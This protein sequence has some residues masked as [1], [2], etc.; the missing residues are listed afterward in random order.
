MSGES[1]SG[2]N[3]D[4]SE[5]PEEL[6]ERAPCALFSTLPNGTIAQGN[7]TFFEWLRAPRESIVGQVR[8]QTLLTIGSRMYYETHYAPLLHM[9]GFVSEIALDIRRADGTVC[10]VVASAK[11]ICDANGVPVSNRVA[12]FDSTDRR[13]YEQELLQARKVAEQ[14]VR[15][16]ADA[17]RQKNAF[18]AMLAHELRNPLAPIRNAVEILRR[19]E[20]M[21]DLTSRTSL[22]MQRQVAQMVRLVEDLL[23]VSRLG[24]AKLAVQRVPVDLV[25]VVR[26]AIEASEGQLEDAG[27]RL[28]ADWPAAPVYVNGDAS[29]LIQVV[30]NI[31][32]NAAKFTPRDGAVHLAVSR[33]DTHAEIRVRD[34]GIGI[35]AAKLSRIFDLFMQ[36][37]I[38]TERRGGL[39]IGL[40]LAKNLV[41][42]HDGEITAH[43]GGVGEGTEFVIRIP[44]LT[45][46]LEGVSK[47]IRGQEPD[48]AMVPKRILVVDDNQD[49]ADMMATLLDLLGHEVKTTY[50][51][52]E[53][54]E[55]AETFRPH[56]ILL[57]IGLPT[58]SGY[59]A[60]ERIR[61]HGGPQPF[62]VALTGWGQTEDRRKSSAA[63]FDAHLIK[64]VEHEVLAK[65]IAD[66]P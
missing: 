46:V 8:F 23:D 2:T 11:Q 19:T 34:T 57:D 24:Q 30:G 43:S 16:L 45:G 50:D 37:E 38:S 62:L 17:D 32:H 42:Q 12:L 60:A 61:R 64:P 35:D 59:E 18:I 28:R 36:V 48:A 33:S 13:R 44:A 56:V 65:L 27:L 3:P 66:L 15:D 20:H 14:S 52:L 21:S 63:G 9:Q 55:L 25:S 47:S 22:M 6:Y 40:M 4:G 54:V 29:R 7:E 53:A 10:P 49:S 5:S 1:E 58:L 31:L 39:G 26:H 51:G 41:E